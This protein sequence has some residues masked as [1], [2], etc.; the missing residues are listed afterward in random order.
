MTRHA[1]ASGLTFVVFA[2]ILTAWGDPASGHLAQACLLALAAGYAASAALSP[3]P[4]KLPWPALAIALPAIWGC[5]Q[6]FAGGTA[7]AH[8]TWD[9]V[10]TWLSR[11]AAFVLAACTFN[12]R[13]RRRFLAVLVVVAA[14]MSLFG[15]VEWFTSQGRIAWLIPV[16][17]VE[18]VIGTFPNRDHYAAFIEL[19]LPVALW[20]ALTGPRPSPW[21][22][23]A[24]GAMFA[25]V[26]V[27][28]SRAGIV[29][30]TLEVLVLVALA[31]LKNQV[32]LRRIGPAVALIVL[33]T[34]IGGGG[35]YALSRFR[36]P[37]P[38]AF[39]KKL[40]VATAEMIRQRPLAGF[41]LGT[42]PTVYPAYAVF[43][44]PGLFMNHAHNDWAEWTAECGVIGLVP[45]LILAFTAA[46]AAIH[47]P[48]CAGTAAVLLHS[49]VDFPMQKISLGLLA[50]TLLGAAFSDDR[51]RH[52]T[53]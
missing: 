46:R 18:A 12:D 6:A 47:K 1:V 48:W 30:A 43:D 24:A 31:R 34:L 35:G 20:R 14:A 42:W 36:T 53:R 7:Y 4:V 25:S 52:D 40:L 28:A 50:M 17:G 13:M 9:G 15:V 22:M 26:A 27:C 44:P 51:R 38:F 21:L 32:S 37:N 8:A 3:T 16:R 11:L 45:L 23:T 5:A 41:G 2:A 49:L 10:A 33:C 29:V 19:A 39:R